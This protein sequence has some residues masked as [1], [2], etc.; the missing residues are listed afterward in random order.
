M[1]IECIEK[2]IVGLEKIDVEFK[3]TYKTITDK[4]L[5]QNSRKL[6]KTS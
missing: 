6:S 2:V 5:N 4:R 3:V 1:I